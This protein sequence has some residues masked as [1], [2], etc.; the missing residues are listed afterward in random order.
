MEKAARTGTERDRKI[1]T[2]PDRHGVRAMFNVIVRNI[3]IDTCTFANV[4]RV[5]F[6]SIHPFRCHS[7]AWTNT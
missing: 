2:H 7:Q 1:D 4:K 5:I 3:Y 6:I